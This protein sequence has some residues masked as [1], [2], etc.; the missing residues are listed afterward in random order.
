MYICKTK[1]FFM[2]HIST[3]EK[4]M[5]EVINEINEPG[6]IGM[7]QQKAKPEYTPSAS[8]IDKLVRYS[9]SL[10]VLH[11]QSIGTMFSIAN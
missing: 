8:L 10:D 2:K 7:K 11:S 4:V 9:Q 5:D 1:P 6:N 3:F